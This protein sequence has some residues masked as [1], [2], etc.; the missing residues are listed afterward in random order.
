MFKRVG[1]KVF[2]AVTC[3]VICCTQSVD[4]GQ[5]DLRS[6]KEHFERAEAYSANGDARAEQEYR[7]A[8]AD[9]GGVYPD[10]WQSLSSYLAQNLRFD[11]SAIALKMYVKQTKQPKATHLER[12]RRLNKAADLKARSQSGDTLSVDEAMELTRLV[13][14]FGVKGA[15]V[16][17]AERAVEQHPESAKTL[18]AFAELIR[19]EQKDRALDLL[20][21]AVAFEPNEPS[22][23][24]ARGWCYF[25][26]YGNPVASEMDF[27]RAIEL[28]NG[29]N[30]SAWAG[31]G[32][33]LARQ[34][35]RAEAIAAYRRYLA[36][37]PKSAAQ[38]DGEIMKSIEML[39][40]NSS[41]R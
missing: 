33:S 19:W 25:W 10:A 21:R 1:W 32:D 29:A 28:S 22:M 41:H 27:L 37:R 16:P 34:G 35:R 5:S 6:S 9:R 24:T 2:I 40:S 36:I 26:A 12:L 18:V 30:V 15:A 7:Q 3:G 23:Y 11:E 38:Y 31:L 14:G 17:Y 4:G 39:S 13:D 20:N 8:I